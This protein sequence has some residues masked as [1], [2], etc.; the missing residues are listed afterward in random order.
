MHCSLSVRLFGG[1]E[2]DWLGPV[3]VSACP[4]LLSRCRCTCLCLTLYVEFSA[5]TGSI[6]PVLPL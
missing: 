1:G 5:D 4:V 6:R 3:V 2:G